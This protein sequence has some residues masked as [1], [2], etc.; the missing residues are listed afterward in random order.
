MQVVKEYPNG[1][2]SWVDLATTDVEGAKAFYGG[3]FGW[4]FVDI[5]TDQSAPYTM[6]TLEGYNVA[7][8]G[9]LPPDMQAQ[10]IPPNWTSYIKHDNVDAVAEKITAAG[11]NLSLP[12][13]DV[14]DS[15]RMLMATDPGGAVFGVWQPRT[16]IGAQLVNIPNT[17]TWN[18]L[19][20]RALDASKEF[21]TAAL[22]WRYEAD[23]NDYNVVFAGDR[24]QAGMMAIGEDWGD[25]PNNWT[26][27][28]LV[29]DIE[30]AV[31]RIGDLGG[32]VMVPITSAG[33]VGRFAAFQDPQGAVT[34]IIEYKGEASPPPGY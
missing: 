10:G 24:S 1:V 29:D 27:Y 33:E 28:F 16:H 8:M 19:Q 5:P 3:L 6:A 9:P 18:E 12:P 22:G 31:A 20:T 34:S 14:M 17:F 32:T 7:G 15:G 26:I 30:A 2:F 4:E 21:Y 13:M 25:V 23:Q 11:G